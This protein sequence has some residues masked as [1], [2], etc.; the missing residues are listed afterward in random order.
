M[1]LKTQ[2]GCKIFSCC[3]IGIALVTLPVFFACAPLRDSVLKDV[4]QNYTISG[5][6]D[7]NTYQVF[8]PLGEA[9]E[10]LASCSA[11]MLEGLVSYK[12]KYDNEASRRRTHTDFTPFATP[13]NIND[14]DIERWKNFYRR[15]MENHTRIV[16]EQYKEGKITGVFR[17]RTEG[18][19]YRVQNVR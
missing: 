15:L 13:E 2:I 17:L 12:R 3:V 18:L 5:F 1:L 16:Y 8:C 4:E 11:T 19:I 6:L 9:D 14:K 7:V 10:R